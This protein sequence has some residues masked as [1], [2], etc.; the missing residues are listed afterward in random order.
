MISGSTQHSNE[1]D[2]PSEDE[3][4]VD[5]EDNEEQQE[6]DD[7]DEEVVSDDEYSQ[8]AQRPRM[9]WELDADLDDIHWGNGAV[10]SVIREYVVGSV[11]Q[12]YGS[13]EVSLSTPQYGFKK[14][15]EVFQ[16]AGYDAISRN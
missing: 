10:G 5:P 2:D 4:T 13:L 3:A 6:D 15:L 11:I 9:V 14:G 16:D 12:H 1:Q 8:G 7:L